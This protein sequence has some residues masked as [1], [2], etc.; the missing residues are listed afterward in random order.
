M[1]WISFKIDPQNSLS[2]C[3]FPTIIS[4]CICVVELRDSYVPST[5]FLIHLIILCFIHQNMHHVHAFTKLIITHSIYIALLAADKRSLWKEVRRPKDGA[6]L[7]QEYRSEVDFQ[8]SISRGS[9]FFR[10]YATFLWRFD[11]TIWGIWLHSSGLHLAYDFLQCNIQAPKAQPH[12][13]GK[14]IHS[15][16][17]LSVGRSWSNSL[18]EANSSWCQNISLVC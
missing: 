12:I 5:S 1:K 13:L 17:F 2:S 15:S 6:I 8:V 4:A 11:G 3:H 9:N 18:C 14:H 7:H 16:I 10:R